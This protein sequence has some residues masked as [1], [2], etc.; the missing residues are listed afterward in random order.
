[1]SSLVPRSKLIFTLFLLTI[2][3]SVLASGQLLLAT[4]L[5]FI[6]AGAT[7]LQLRNARG[8]RNRAAV[9]H[10][11]FWLG[12]TA[13]LASIAVADIIRSVAG[14]LL[15]STSASLRLPPI[16]DTL[17]ATWAG[18]LFVVMVGFVPQRVRKFKNAFIA[19][20]LSFLPYLA[21]APWRSGADPLVFLIMQ[22]TAWATCVSLLMRFGPRSYQVRTP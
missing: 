18:I 1:M 13:I 6:V 22:I 9:P 5:Y 4:T 15:H 16:S 11:L 2:V 17:L 10:R 21:L 12:P 3:V 14:A 7:V 8:T 20:P 19:L